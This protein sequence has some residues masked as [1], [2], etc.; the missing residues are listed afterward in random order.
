MIRKLEDQDIEQSLALSQYAFQYQLSPE[1]AVERRERAKLHE[2]WGEFEGEQLIS[3]LH[4]L[5]LKIYIA[6]KSFSMGGVAGVATW[7]EHRR[8]GSVSRLIRQALVSM[9]ETGHSISLLHPFSFAFYRR[10]GWEWFVSYKTY[11]LDAAHLTL[12]P[13]TKGRV[14]RLTERS[15]TSLLREMYQ[16]FASGY[17]GMLDRSLDWWDYHVKPFS[18]QV[19]VYRNSEDQP[20][21]YVLYQVKDR[22]LEVEEYIFLNEEARIGLW[23]FLCQH[24]SMVD[25]IKM[26]VAED[27]RLPYLLANPKF[28]QE[29]TPYFM[30]RI[31]DVEMF[32]RRYPL[33]KQAGSISIQVEDPWAKWNEGIYE[34][35]D[36]LVSRIHATHAKAALT[37]DINTL[38]AIF[39]GV[40]SASFFYELGRLKGESADVIELERLI[41]K[42]ATALFDFF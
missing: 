12:L 13:S 3:K 18:Y 32:L 38:T 41:P 21:G 11:K 10:Y 31:V 19:G 29:V 14:E 30:A 24:D 25:Q 37:C 6:H 23:N 16:R 40:Q 5:P 36:G 26:R 39:L 27:D 1:Q 9:K 34:I 2:I 7:P 35:Q 22:M 4:I 8:K 15:G 28:Q 20:R 17:S 42:Q 33:A